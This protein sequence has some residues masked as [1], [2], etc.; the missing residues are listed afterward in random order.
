MS[1]FTTPHQSK[2]FRV[3][4][5]DFAPQVEVAGCYIH[6][7]ENY[8]WLHRS[9]GK[10][11]EF[12]WGVPAGKIEVG[13]NP[14]Q[15]VVREVREETGICLDDD[16]LVFVGSLY[17]RDP[18]SDFIYHMFTQE[19]SKR[20]TVHLSDEHHDHRWVSISDALNL[21]LIS[22]GKEALYQFLALVSQPP[23]PRKSFYFVR[24]GE[25]DVNAD[26]SI[27]RMD[28]DLPLNQKG[29]NQA[30]IAR[31]IASKLA[32]ST[33]RFSPIQRAKETKEIIAESTDAEHIG[34]DRLSE[35][36]AEVWNKMVK[37]ED[38]N[39]YDVCALVQDFLSRALMGAAAALQDNEPALV[40]AHGGIHWALCYHMMI[41]HHPWKIGN[42]EVVRFDP[43]GENRWSAT[44]IS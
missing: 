2:V 25:T 28:Y 29:I 18:Q 24:H 42:C 16:C 35:C 17:V 19:Y 11:Q 41:E 22:G 7:D 40:V 38:G 9:R 21:P 43:V 1:L 20:P 32:I 27:K 34:D 37:L 8:L 12:T 30:N 23:L 26:P 39:G 15:A 44:V 4:P 31:D 10:P 6:S 5:D 33:I 13:E 3:R 14:R 36:K